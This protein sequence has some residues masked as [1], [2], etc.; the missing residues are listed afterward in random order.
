MDSNKNFLCV[1]VGVYPTECSPELAL[2]TT[3]IHVGD[4]K[5][6]LERGDEGSGVGIAAGNVFKVKERVVLLLECHLCISASEQCLGAERVCGESFKPRVHEY[7]GA[8]GFT[9]C[10]R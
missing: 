2:E 9:L 5:L 3:G 10:K 4:I 6:A 7:K 8:L 1:I